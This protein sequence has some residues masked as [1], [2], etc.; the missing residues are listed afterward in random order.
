MADRKWTILLVGDERTEVRQFRLSRDVVRSG[1]ALLLLTFS[2][3]VTLIT[4]VSIRINAPR[5]ETN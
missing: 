5:Q 2:L 3:L 1:L 4:Q